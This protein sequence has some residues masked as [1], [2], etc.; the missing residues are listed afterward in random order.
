MVDP[1]INH[2]MRMFDFELNPKQLHPFDKIKS[3]GR[4]QLECASLVFAEFMTLH[5]RNIRGLTYPRKSWWDFF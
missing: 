2:I 3:I 4:R 5:P 1:F